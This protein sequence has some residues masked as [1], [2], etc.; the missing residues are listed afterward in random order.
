MV[1][2]S[3]GPSVKSPKSYSI[4]IIYY[5]SRN[6]RIADSSLV[7]FDTVSLVCGFWC[8]EGM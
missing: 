8:F 2:N 4:L 6:S 7:G 5:F 1:M 3:F